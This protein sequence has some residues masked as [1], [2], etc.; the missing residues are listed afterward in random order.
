M[1]TSRRH[2]SWPLSRAA[3]LLS[4]LAIFALLSAPALAAE[5]EK[6]PS[7]AILIAEL[8]VL[9]VA[10]RL[11]GEGMLR[12][13][14]PAVMGQLLAGLILGP[15]VFGLIWP[16][17]QHALFPHTPEQKSMVDGISQFGILLL[18][19]LTGM[20]T[21]LKL[22]RRVGHAA[23]SVSVAGVA[24]PFACGVA[25]GEFL[26]DQLLPDAGQRLVT[27]LFLGTAL[28]I[29]SIKIVAAIV[30][31]MNFTR[32]DLGQV[33]VSSAIVEDTIGWTIIPITF[34]LAQSGRI[35]LASVAKSVI[36]TAVFLAA[37]LTVG[38]RAVALAIRWV[39]DY[40]ASEFAVITTI[41]V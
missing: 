25:L 24:V 29:S 36:G 39:N 11:L 13:G 35:D 27:A 30:R 2:I 41:L 32:R 26:P 17:A 1:I 23:L 31:D 21:D 10:G 6:A 40:F 20:E 4:V 12:V 38:R 3:S 9:M 37:S 33:I 34:S 15:S 18:L 16:D 14:Q 22:V 5:G 28:S 19:L 8:V 7:E